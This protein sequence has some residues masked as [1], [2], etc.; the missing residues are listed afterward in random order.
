MKLTDLYSFKE[1]N[2]V[3]TG[4]AGVLGGE[5]ARALIEA[6]AKVAI[7]D[8]EIKSAEQLIEQMGCPVRYWRWKLTHPLVPPLK[9]M[10]VK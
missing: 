6:G 4:G 10:V 1:F 7:I 5:I 3:I 8:R 2:V 9:R